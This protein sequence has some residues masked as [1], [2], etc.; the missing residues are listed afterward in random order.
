MGLTGA[1]GLQGFGGDER[2]MGW[3]AIESSR[4][5]RV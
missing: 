1:K 5:R 4:V 2:E 3:R